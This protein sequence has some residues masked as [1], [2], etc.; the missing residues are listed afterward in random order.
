MPRSATVARTALRGLAAVAPPLAVP[1]AARAFWRVGPPAPVR[2]TDRAVHERARRGT[3]RAGGLPVVT[4]AWGDPAA[5]PVLLSHG[6][7]LRASRFAP[8]VTALTA[9][10]LRPVAFDA[11]AHG[12]SPGRRTTVL[13]HM[14]AM[15][16][17]EHAEGPFAGVV[18][19]SL[20]GLGAGLALHEGLDA[21]RFVAIAAPTGFDSIAASFLRLAGLPGTLHEPFCRRVVRP[22]PPQVGNPR[23]TVDLVVRPVPA[24]V[25]ALFVQDR[26]DRMA[27]PGDAERLHAAHPGSSL[28][29]TDGLGHNRVL[30]DP[31]VLDAVV[32]H[33]TAPAA[34]PAAREKLARSYRES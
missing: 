19:H 28:L 16:A 8:L 4:Y 34:V 13:D 23:T 17:L 14:A 15:R 7:Q 33:L 2:P 9:A 3:V 24:S 22:F 12:D 26:R 31:G 6:W 30:D 25:P 1:L 18:G 29:L 10:G 11:V 5:P 27:G 21:A 20:G 32:A